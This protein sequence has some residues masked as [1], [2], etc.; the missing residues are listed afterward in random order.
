MV[1]SVWGLDAMCRRVATN[2]SSLFPSRTGITTQNSVRPPTRCSSPICTESTIRSE[3]RPRPWIDSGSDSSAGMFNPIV[4]PLSVPTD[5]RRRPVSLQS[6]IGRPES[7]RT[8]RRRNAARAA[9][10]LCGAGDTRA[11]RIAASSATRAKRTWVVRMPLPVTITSCLTLR[12]SPTCASLM[13]ARV[14]VAHTTTTAM[15]RTAA[16]IAVLA[17]DSVWAADSR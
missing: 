1:A 16:T 9:P 13:A 17:S 2:P 14:S 4:S 11:L 15:P 3:S 6:S 5:P 7:G 8:S 12:S 10:R